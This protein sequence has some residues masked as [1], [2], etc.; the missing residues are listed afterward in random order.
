[1][2]RPSGPCPSKIMIVG[3]I[4]GDR[5]ILK[6]LPFEGTA[7]DELSRML[8]DAGILRSLCFIS[9]VCRAKLPGG[10]D[11]AFPKAKKDRTDNHTEHNGVVVHK[12]VL[13]GMSL[14]QREIEM[15][16]PNVI[17]ALGKVALF[18][19]TGETA[20]GDWRGSVMLC[21]LPT[22]LDYQ[23]KVVPTY[24][25]S[26]VL[27]V[28]E[29]RPVV[30]QDFR[31]ALKE[32]ASP[33]YIRPKYEFVLRPTF[34]QAIGTLRSMI[35][36][37]KASPEQTLRL[38]CD[39]ETRMGRIAC[40]GFA[41][42]KT[43]AICIPLLC[44]ERLDGYWSLEEEVALIKAMRELF[45][46]PNLE[47]VGQNFSYDAQYIF[48]YWL[49]IPE[50]IRDTMIAQHVCFAGM[51]KSLDYLSSMYCEHH[52][53]WKDDGKEWRKDMDEDR[54]WAYNCQDAVITFE[55]WGVLEKVVRAYKLD[56]V[57]EF[58]QR[59]FYPVLRM[60]LRG[61]RNDP[62]RRATFAGE[63]M[64]ELNARQNWINH[65]SGELL[66]I[67]S[68]K[69]MIQFFYTIMRQKPNY[70][71]KGRERSLT[72]DDEALGKIAQR[73]PLLKPM[74][75]KISELRSIGVFLST[76]VNSSMD[77]DGRIRCSYNIAGTDTFRFASSK[78][79]FGSG[80][81]LQNIP[82][83]SEADGL[84][85]PNVR[86]LFLPDPGKE[87]FDIDL[88]SADLRIV[89]WE[90]DEGEMKRMLA[91]GYDPY[92]VI[93]Q[94]FY[95]DQTI[96]KKDP[97]RQTFKSFAH[98]T[99]YLGTAKGLAERLGLTVHEAEKTQKWYFQRFPKIKRWQDN[100]KD[101]VFKRK[102][103][104]NIFGYRFN[105]LGRIDQSALNAAAAWTPQ[106]TVACLI[107]RALV[108][109][110][111]ELPEVEILLQVHDSLAGQYPLQ[112]AE[113]HRAAILEKASIVLPYDD[114]LIIPV[115][116]KTSPI[117]WGDCA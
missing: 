60:M 12:E 30:L 38:A 99:H 47:C 37:L 114:P 92:T 100:L 45:R 83:G 44:V 73:E 13:A 69:Q 71:R 88:S 102:Y 4:P 58:Q 117:S 2:I 5:E 108:R 9:V 85:L 46:Q 111:A 48:R 49:V 94:E 57:N 72:C 29:R 115:G 70:S 67:K 25:P 63:L 64:R 26:L 50:G 7:G 41:W 61:V 36:Q 78:N 6:G 40:I 43:Q 74:V 91:E 59:L 55:V 76:F 107:N 52:L 95:H 109:I 89:V 8:A 32:S 68:S 35:Q 31:R 24:S 75:N 10:V 15:C 34:A 1:M 39:I 62:K 98:G 51:E 11:E 84:V 103:V 53:Y 80:L 23:P 96:N 22:A 97:R 112:N 18:A 87:F 3:E 104:Q 14:L 65:V 113:T 66:N 81:N 116:I 28:W 54:L 77:V 20:I 27:Q 56:E 17:I 21:N 19:L 82:N 105:I 42:S 86:K 110:D 93:A 79:A 101:Q 90:A 106:S 33:T 16:R